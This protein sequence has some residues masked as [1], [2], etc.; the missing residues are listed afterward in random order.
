MS[1]KSANHPTDIWS[2]FHLK[3]RRTEKSRT[4]VGGATLQS[5]MRFAQRNIATHDTS[6]KIAEGV[7]PKS[8]SLIPKTPARPG[9][10]CNSV[11]II[12][13]PGKNSTVAKASPMPDRSVSKSMNSDGL[14]FIPT[15][16]VYSTARARIG[17]LKQ[18]VPKSGS[19][20]NGNNIL[21]FNRR[22]HKAQMGANRRICD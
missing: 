13:S 5:S 10:T 7:S 21:K 4:C 17:Q 1:P 8:I 15:S 14:L 11:K 6:D 16:D 22:W 12:V 19:R 18:V 9:I 2:R 3:R 20:F